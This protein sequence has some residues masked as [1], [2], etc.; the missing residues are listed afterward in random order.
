MLLEE[1][2][3]Y[4]KRYEFYLNLSSNKEIHWFQ[5][6]PTYLLQ[7]LYVLMAAVQ[8]MDLLPEF[9][10]R[11]ASRVRK[12]VVMAFLPPNEMHSTNFSSEV[13]PAA[14][15]VYGLQLLHKK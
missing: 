13:V 5:I 14:Q 7:K 12:H 11:S 9:D 8:D 1:I 15:F 10:D 2:N 6:S 4:N 3:R